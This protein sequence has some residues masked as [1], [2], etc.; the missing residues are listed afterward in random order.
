MIKPRPLAVIRK[1]RLNSVALLDPLRSV[2]FSSAHGQRYPN[3]VE[4]QFFHQE[5]FWYT[6]PNF[7]KKIKSNE[8]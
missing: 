4:K 1:R 8:K 2:Q 3:Q 7:F 6:V 5:V